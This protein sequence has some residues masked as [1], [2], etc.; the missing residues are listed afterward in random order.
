MAKIV[1]IEHIILLLSLYK[2]IGADD[3]TSA[4]VKDISKTF[5]L[6]SPT[7]LHIK[8]EVPI[9]CWTYQWVLCLSHEDNENE[10]VEHIVFLHK[11]SKQDS[12]IFL[13]NNDDLL[14]Y[15]ALFRSNYP[16]FMPLKLA[17][18]KQLKLDSN[19][20]FFETLGTEIRLVDI[21][22]VN[23][24]NLIT[25]EMGIW[26]ERVGVKLKQHLS[27][28]DRRRDLMGAVFRNTLWEF[29]FWAKFVYDK[30]GTIIGSRGWFQEKLFYVTEGLNFTI[31]IVEE[32]MLV[33]YTKTYVTCEKLLL[34]NLTDICSGGLPIRFPTLGGKETP[35]QLSIATGWN[36]NTLIAGV[37]TRTAIDAWSYV[38]VFDYPTWLIY[39]SM[40]IMLYLGVTFINTVS[41]SKHADQ[42]TFYDNF[43]ITLLFVI[44]QGNHPTCEQTAARRFLTITM[45]IL[46]FLVFICYSNDI[47]AKMTV[48]SPTHPVRAFEDVLDQGYEVITVGNHFYLDLKDSKI[49]TAKHSVY[50]QYFE[51]YDDEIQEWET[52]PKT[53]GQK[54][55]VEDVEKWWEGAEENVNWALEQIIIDNN[56]LLYA[57]VNAGGTK[58]NEGKVVPLKMEDSI[59]VYGGFWFGVDSEYLSMFNHYFLKG[60]ETG[61]FKRLDITYNAHLKPPIKIGLTEPGPLGI[62]NVI[63]LFS[64]LGVAALLSFIIAVL[65][66]WVK[67]MNMVT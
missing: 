36:V 43:V 64:F 6:K 27:R 32:M 1:N 35:L 44:Q 31:K 17:S 40:L 12:L 19:I 14:K 8:D 11:L 30:Y 63:F 53:L 15:L 66:I 37:Q 67:K 26:N 13:D 9:V 16:I 54:E 23:G 5:N 18:R 52:Q 4:F 62:N 28:W 42:S 25:L 24:G 47:T 3:V 60:L 61:I 21:F 22:A 45:S 34:L 46:T 55:A 7:I 51:E 49:G 33:N 59:K 20:I 56:K 10:L 58:I 39:F 38:K 41:L 2:V 29:E 57:V 48:G 50:K 65:E